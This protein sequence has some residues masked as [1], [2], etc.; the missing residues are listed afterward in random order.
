LN[1]LAHFQRAWPEEE[2]VVGALEGDYLKG[3][4]KGH[5]PKG[6]ELGV[7]LHRAIDAFTDQHPK[8]A[9]L[10]AQFPLELRRYSGILIDLSFDHYLSKHWHNYST[11][12][13]D[14]FNATIYRNLESH[15]HHLGPGARRMLLR[16]QQHDLLSVYGQWDSIA[17]TAARIGER[18]QRENPFLQV[19]QHLDPV[20]PQLELSFLNFYPDLI[21][22][23]G[24]KKHQWN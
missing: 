10:R 21:E 11:L 7:K 9:E 4:L 17:A 24:L 22:F 3:P 5:L 13:L 19:A 20:R 16:M 6:I 14:A 1:F 18:F 8:M 12:P 23:C 2:L 15:K